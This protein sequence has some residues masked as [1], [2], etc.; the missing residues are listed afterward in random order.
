M[1]GFFFLFFSF[2]DGDFNLNSKN[3]C[4]AFGSWAWRAFLMDQIA[5]DAEGS[6][7]LQGLN[8]SWEPSSAL[9]PLEE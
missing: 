1:G 2:L 4:K 5:G 6:H 9:W 7:F 8:K 3:P